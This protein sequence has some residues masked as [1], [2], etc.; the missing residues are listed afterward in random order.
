MTGAE[1][2]DA[3]VTMFEN[4]LR[5]RASAAPERMRHASRAQAR[6]L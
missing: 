3:F 2:A 1:I 4:G 6:A 5:P